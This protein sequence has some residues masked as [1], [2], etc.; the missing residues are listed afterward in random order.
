[1]EYQKINTIF[2]RDT[3]NMIMPYDNLVAPEFEYLRNVKWHCEE[4]IDG[5]NIRLEI[6]KQ[7]VEDGVNFVVNYGGRTDNAQ[8]PTH[9]LQF[10]KSNFPDEKILASVGLKSFIP[11]SEFAEHK[12]ND[13]DSIP[14]IYAIYGEGY[15]VKIQ[16]GGNYIK[17]GVGFIVFDVRVNDVWLKVDARNE[18]AEKLGAPVVPFIGDMTIDEAIAFVKKGFKSTIAE[19]K[20]Y[21]AEGL[22]LRTDLG[23]CDRMGRRLICKI[24]TVDFI[25]YRQTYGTDDKVEQIKNAHIKD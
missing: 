11:T 13:Y 24:K 16:K 25:K 6:T 14:N 23:L 18:I 20:D 15:G 19:N 7:M 3:K 1:M 5:T 22:V 12:W 21:D 17:D 2:Y 9:L 8:I 4:K 10:L